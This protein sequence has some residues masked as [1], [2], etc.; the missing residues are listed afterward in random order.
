MTPHSPVN[1]PGQVINEGRIHFGHLSNESSVIEEGEMERAQS[2]LE[3]E[4]A[5]ELKEAPPVIVARGQTG[6]VVLV[7][8]LDQVNKVQCLEAGCVLEQVFKT[9]LLENGSSE[10]D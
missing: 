5:Q 1:Q 4:S 8:A 10:Y 3:R 7:V 2:R 9:R 6:V